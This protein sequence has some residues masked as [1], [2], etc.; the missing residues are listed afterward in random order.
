M[1][2]TQEQVRMA[3]EAGLELLAPESEIKIPTKLNDGVFFLKGLLAGIAQGR[4]TLATAVQEEPPQP[5][6]ATPGKK[7]PPADP[8]KQRQAKKK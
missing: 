8:K 1:N 7:G 2:M 6:V 5:P 4:L 3:I